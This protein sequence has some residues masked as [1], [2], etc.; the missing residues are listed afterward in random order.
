M[1]ATTLRY[2]RLLT[3][4]IVVAGRQRL[5]D[6]LTLRADGELLRIPAG[7]PDLAAQRLDGRAEDRGLHH[8]VLVDVVREP[9]M[10]AMRRIDLEVFVNLQVAVWH[11]F[12]AHNTKPTFSGA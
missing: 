12:G 10:I 4:V 3:G 5:V 11:N 8:V 7:H 1:A 9:L 2:S 6:F